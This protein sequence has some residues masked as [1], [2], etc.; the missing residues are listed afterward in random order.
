MTRGVMVNPTVVWIILGGMALVNLGLVQVALLGGNTPGPETLEYF[1][2]EHIQRAVDYQGA[3]LG[4][5]VLQQVL[6]LA[7]YGAAAAWLAGRLQGTRFFST[8]EIARYLFIFFVGLHLLLLPL[9]FYRGF[10]IEHQFALSTRGAGPWL[11]DYFKSASI[12]TLVSTAAYSGLYALMLYYPRY[13]WGLAGTGFFVFLL[14]GS[15]LSPVVIDPLFHDFAPLEDKVME[16]E[17]VGMANRAGIPVE[18]VLVADASRRTR[19][20][21][22]Y[23]TG[24]GGTRRIVL[25]DNLVNNFSREEVMVVVAHEMGHWKYRHIPLGITLGALGALGGFLLIQ[26]TL[27]GMGVGV[28][29][30][31]LFLFMLL[32]SLLSLASLPVQNYLSRC[33]E[34][35]A[36][37]EALLLTE[38]P[39]AFVSLK[40]ELARSNLS[41]VEPHP[42]I[43]FVLSTHPPVMERIKSAVTQGQG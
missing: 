30:R 19:K 32:Y 34:R 1:D 25:Y 5:F 35:Q 14:L 27:Q 42:F 20:V 7:I 31:A 3:R 8:L 2:R 6:M 4:S 18:G 29:L 9:A 37:R 39:Q 12:S 40:Q 22:A 13:W 11:V 26:L 16:G 10:I 23:F 41:V 24:I 36:D 28:N 43:K 17:I 33:F 21:N 15:Y 38:D